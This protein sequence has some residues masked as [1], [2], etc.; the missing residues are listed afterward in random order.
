[1]ADNTINGAN[2]SEILRA[3]FESFKK[4]LVPASA[5][6]TL[7]NSVNSE[8]VVSRIFSPKTGKAFVGD[9]T[10]D[11]ESTTTEV[12]V[13][14]DQSTFQ[15]FYL[16]DT[17]ASKTPVDLFRG[18]AVE[19]GY[20]VGRG[21]LDYIM[22][23]I[24]ATNYGNT[25]SDKITVSSAAFDVD[26]VVD[27]MKLAL[28]KGWD[29]GSLVLSYGYAAALLKDNA[30]K[31]ASAFGTGGTSAPI[32]SGRIGTLMGFPVY[33]YPVPANSENLAGFLAHPSSLAVAVRPMTT[34][35]DS[36]GVAT[37]RAEVISDADSGLSMASRV[38]YEDKSGRLYGAYHVLYGATKAKS[39]G[40]IRI[41][42]A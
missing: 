3:G 28:D 17:E 5:F 18:Y 8:S 35:A 15:N 25:A 12:K 30:I 2:L 19:A 20:A 41:V 6:T 33:T 23:L 36:V 11:P 37:T 31:D 40:L 13:N 7:F 32:R 21:V 22:G 4:A 24:T 9:Y 42:S 29:N 26:D 14:F 39:D 38:F 34:L 27:A 1:M 16:S 10:A